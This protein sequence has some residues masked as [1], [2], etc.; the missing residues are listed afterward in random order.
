MREARI[1]TAAHLCAL[2]VWQASIALRPKKSPV[3]QEPTPSQ[4]LLN[5]LYARTENT[6]K[7]AVE[8]VRSVYLDI[9]VKEGRWFRVKLA[10]GQRKGRLLALCVEPATGVPQLSRPSAPMELT[11]ELDQALALH[12]KEDSR[13]WM[14]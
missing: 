2:I 4:D 13:A 3:L 12:V 5:A 6:L 8:S 7:L 11:L 14:V 9:P 10:T 1:P